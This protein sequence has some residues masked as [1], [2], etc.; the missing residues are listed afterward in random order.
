MPITRPS[1][2][3]DITFTPVIGATYGGSDDWLGLG[4]DVAEIIL[5]DQ[6]TSADAAKIETY[7]AVKYGIT[8]NKGGSN[9]VDTDGNPVWQVDATYKYN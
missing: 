3:G 8:L 5:Y 7:L 2:F 4:A 1:N 9:Y 6:L